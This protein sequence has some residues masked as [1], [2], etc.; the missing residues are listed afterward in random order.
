MTQSLMLKLFYAKI[1]FVTLERRR[2]TNVIEVVFKLDTF[3]NK[4]KCY[5]CQDNHTNKDTGHARA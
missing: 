1:G 3:N 5:L 2:I 4:T